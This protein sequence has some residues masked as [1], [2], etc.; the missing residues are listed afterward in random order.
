MPA[1]GYLL[2]LNENVHHYLSVPYDGWLLRHLSLQTLWRVWLLFYGTFLLA[3]ATVLYS[4]HCS[5]E[6][7]RYTTAFEMADGETEHQYNLGQ[8]EIEAA[9]LGNLIAQQS[10]WERQL[11]DLSK[12]Q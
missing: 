7:K 6:I 11:V 8:F 12:G 10:E 3:I 4:Y 5:P 2:L 1:F 9:L